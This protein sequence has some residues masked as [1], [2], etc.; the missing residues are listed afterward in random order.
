MPPNAELIV[1]DLWRQYEGVGDVLKGVS[2]TIAKGDSVSIVGPSGSGKSTLL[3]IVGSLETPTA[4]QVRL[5]DVNVTA[6]SGRALADYRARKVGFVFQDHYLLPQCTAIE[7]VMLPT[8][9]AK[10]LRE[11]AESRSR[12]L[13]A[14]VGLGDRHNAFPAEL[15]GGERQRVAVARALVNRPSLLLC[16]EPTGNLDRETGRQVMDLFV[17]MSEETGATLLVVTHDE[18]AA[19]RLRSRYALVDGILS[20][21]AA[22][23]GSEH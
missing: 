12:S 6:L 22:P 18:A 5:G 10:D 13:L 19:G 17:Q 7:N 16:D 4:G 8:F 2:L 20:E 9:T 11:D 3:N 21:S 15:S 14:S 1:E 23:R